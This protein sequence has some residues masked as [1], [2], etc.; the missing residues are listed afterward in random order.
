MKKFLL[1]LYLIFQITYTIYGMALYSDLHN[2]YQYGF[3]T[4]LTISVIYFIF[5]FCSI[6]STIATFKL[7]KCKNLKSIEKISLITYP[8][9]FVYIVLI[10]FGLTECLD[11]L[12]QLFINSCDII[13]DYGR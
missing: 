2:S 5:L 9:L 7:I 12:H 4:V 11:G 3:L 8:I 1:E 13:I 6:F 10:I